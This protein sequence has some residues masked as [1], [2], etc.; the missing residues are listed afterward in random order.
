MTAYTEAEARMATAYYTGNEDTLGGFHEALVT[1]FG[2]ADSA[3]FAKLAL[4]FP[5]LAAAFRANVAEVDFD[6][7]YLGE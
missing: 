7:M 2:R 6:N 5:G 4:G 1:A 3:N